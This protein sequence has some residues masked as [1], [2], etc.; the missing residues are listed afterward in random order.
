MKIITTTSSLMKGRKTVTILL[1]KRRTGRTY[2]DG[3]DG[4]Q[5]VARPFSGCGNARDVVCG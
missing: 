3:D 5:F 1:L 2:L 4:G